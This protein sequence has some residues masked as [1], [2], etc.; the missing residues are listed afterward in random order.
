MDCKK[1]EARTPLNYA[2]GWEARNI[3]GPCLHHS[4]P[5]SLDSNLVTFGECWCQK[6]SSSYIVATF[7]YTF[8]TWYVHQQALA[9]ERPP[10]MGP[11]LLQIGCFIPHSM[12]VTEWVGP[13]SSTLNLFLPF[14]CFSP[15]HIESTASCMRRFGGINDGES[16]TPCIL[17][18]QLFILLNI[19][20]MCRLKILLN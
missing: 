6:A 12:V 2:M 20:R 15:V 9:L 8:F 3:M 11:M 7:P 10:Y 16:H 13:S 5:T 17:I 19:C 18:K 4:G 14:K 1:G